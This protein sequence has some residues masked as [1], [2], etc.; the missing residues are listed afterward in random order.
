MRHQHFTAG[1]GAEPV[2][3]GGEQGEAGILVGD[4]LALQAL[5]QHE[6][7][8]IAGGDERHRAMRIPEGPGAAERRIGDVQPAI[9]EQPGAEGEAAGLVM[10]A[11]NDDDAQAE[12]AD[13]AVED[14]VKQFHGFGRRDGA[15]EDIAGEQ[16]G[17]GAGVAGD[18]EEL[19]EQQMFLVGLQGMAAEAAAQMP[20]GGV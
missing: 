18:V 8:G 16:H 17:V 9:G 14:F 20:V 19:A 6:R 7:R 13:Q 4:R 3:Q 10:V 11:G 1:L 12:A 5:G 2:Q 15:V